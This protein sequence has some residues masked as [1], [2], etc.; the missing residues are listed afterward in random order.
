MMMMRRMLFMTVVGNNCSYYTFIFFMMVVH[1]IDAFIE[2]MKSFRDEVVE[3][4]LTEE[5]DGDG[6]N[7]KEEQK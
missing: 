4:Y 1:S 6:D 2:D 5:N 7:V 3:Y